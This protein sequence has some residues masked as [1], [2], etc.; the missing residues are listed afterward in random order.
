MS[1][2]GGREGAENGPC[3][4]CMTRMYSMFW[5]ALRSLCTLSHAYFCSDLGWLLPA[6]FWVGLG[7]CK[8]M[9]IEHEWIYCWFALSLHDICVYYSLF[10][11]QRLLLSPNLSGFLEFP[12]ARTFFATKKKAQRSKE[13]VNA[14]ITYLCSHL[15]T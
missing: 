2:C 14:I 7:S 6:P 13:Q 9:T 11:H 12:I 15:D 10:V 8:H 3:I 1:E 4:I 5:H